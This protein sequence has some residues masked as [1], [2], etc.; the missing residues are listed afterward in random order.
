VTG[1]SVVAAAAPETGGAAAFTDRAA[2]KEVL[3][4]IIRDLHGGGDVEVLKN[5]FGDLVKDVSGA[6]IGAMEQELIT[7]GLPE[8]EIR[9]L[10]DVHVKVFEE[11]LASQ[12]VPGAGPGHPLR[13]GPWRRSSPRHGG[14]STTSATSRTTGTGRPT[15]S[16]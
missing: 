15:G 2:K 14:S 16:A 9:K 4:D 13:T 1:E 7:E 10:C 5:R 11:S 8:S 12:P 6:E 3:K